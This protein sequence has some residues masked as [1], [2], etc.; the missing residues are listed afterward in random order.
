MAPK[1]H[2]QPVQPKQIF[3]ALR[4]DKTSRYHVV[5]RD[6]LSFSK[7]DNLKAGSCGRFNGG[8]DRSRR[9]QGTVIVCGSKEQCEKYV[10]LVEKS[11]SNNNNRDQP[12][13]GESNSPSELVI[14]ESTEKNDA[15]GN[16]SEESEDENVIVK[17]PS[18]S[19]QNDT[20]TIEN[21][22]SAMSTITTS[23]NTNTAS[24]VKDTTVSSNPTVLQ[25]IN[26]NTDTIPKEKDVSN[27]STSTT[28]KEKRSAVSIIEY[29]KLKLENKRLKKEN[30]MYKNN[31]MPRPTGPT[32]SYFID[33]GKILSGAS[34]NNDVEEDK[35]EKLLSICRTLEMTEKQ[36]LS[37]EHKTDITKTCR[38][39]AK[40]IYPD[41]KERAETLVSIMSSEKLKA[42]Q[43]YAK[44]VHPA[45]AKTS[46]SILNN[47]IENVFAAEKRKME[48][49]EAMKST[50][51][52]EINDSIEDDEDVQ[53]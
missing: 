28:K 50:E 20:Q 7:K 38:Q 32:A 46:N 1:K 10:S 22:N 27:E 36:L 48:I 5:P 26:N 31:W 35:G 9:F 44:M 23:S 14:D 17:N 53:E 24:G 4:D 6:H 51:T 16:E 15:A 3:V 8:N 34:I 30:E 21:N 42:I 25:E 18:K 13:D 12:E 39:I 43:E 47:A 19:R 29:E 52:N 45:Q 41:P 2:K 37:C 40:F 11:N 33:V 49:E